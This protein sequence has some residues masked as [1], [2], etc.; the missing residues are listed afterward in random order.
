MLNLDEVLSANRARYLEHFK[1]LVARDTHCLGHGIEGGLEK[2]GQDYLIDLF[3]QMH[4]TEIRVD[5][6]DEAFIQ[7]G[8]RE[9]NE[10]NPGHVF[11]DRYNVHAR[12]AGSGGPSLMFNG[13][14]DTMPAGDLSR[15]TSPPHAPEL[16]DGRLYGLGTTDMK[17][18]LM[19][20]IMAVKLLQDA[21]CELPGDVIISSVCDEEGGG[22]GSIQAVMQGIKADGVVVCECSSD[23]LI[24]AHMGFV[25][26]RVRIEGLAV[27]SGGKW[28][29]VSAIDKAI[30]IIAALNELEH[31]WLLRCKHPLLPAPNLNVGVIRGGTAGSTVAGDCMFEVCVHYLPQQ[32]S[33]HS[34]VNA[35]MDSLQRVAAA[36]PWLAEQPPT[37]EIYQAGGA[38]EQ[39]EEDPLVD[40]FKAAYEKVYGKKTP[41][42]GSPAGCDSRVWKNIAACPTLQFGPGHLEQ[43][44]SVD[45]YLDIEEF[46]RYIRLYAEL[47]MTDRR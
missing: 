33:Y 24:L 43:C 40:R 44:H 19:A 45:E 28:K 14:I 17:G 21:G 4:A 11:T 25:F 6:M 3:R 9:H 36:D 13:H 10:G 27:H 30:K 37:V 29:G 7:A 26:F 5:P 31:G 41:I 35:F 12:F 2:A 46:F 38:F 23:E 18:G 34:V 39:S 1:E 16:R 8:M 42:A 20:A 47:I 32:M 15:W 22:N